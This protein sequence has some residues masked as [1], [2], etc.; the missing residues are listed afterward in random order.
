MGDVQR[1]YP[2][3]PILYAV[4]LHECHPAGPFDALSARLA[5]ARVMISSIAGPQLERRRV[6]PDRVRHHAALI[7]PAAQLR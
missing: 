1:T 2:G 3:Q 6:K 7:R 4:D 5:D